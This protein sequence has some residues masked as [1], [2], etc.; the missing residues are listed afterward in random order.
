MKNPTASSRVI[1]ASN[2]K[3]GAPQ[4]VGNLP[5]MIHSAAV[6]AMPAKDEEQIAWQTARFA[7]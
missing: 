2:T 5:A 4:G 3:E 6:R 1:G 7:T